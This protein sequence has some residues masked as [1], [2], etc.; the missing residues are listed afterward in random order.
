MMMSGKDF[1]KSHVLRWWR[2]VCSN[3]E[4][5]TSSGRQG[6]SGLSPGFGLDL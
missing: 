5:L 3:W 1:L 4:D 2:K 6:I